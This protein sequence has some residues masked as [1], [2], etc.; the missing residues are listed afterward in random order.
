MVRSWTLGSNAAASQYELGRWTDNDGR[1]AVWS[2]VFSFD[3]RR[4]VTSHGDGTI[5]LWDTASGE[6]LASFEGGDSRFPIQI[7][8]SADGRRAITQGF[9]DKSIYPWNLPASD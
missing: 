3:G 9:D 6:E 1:G 7:H 4:I 5:K 2:G 8:L